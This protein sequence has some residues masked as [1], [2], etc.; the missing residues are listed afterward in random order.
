MHL[1][2]MWVHLENGAGEYLPRKHTVLVKPAPNAS[3]RHYRRCTR[4]LVFPLPPAL[5]HGS[6]HVPCRPGLRYDSGGAIMRTCIQAAGKI[7]LVIPLG[8]GM[9]VS[10]L[11]ASAQATS[12]SKALP[13]PDDSTAVQGKPN[14][15]KRAQLNLPPPK[16]W[17]NP[18]VHERPYAF[19]RSDV[20]EYRPTPKDSDFRLESRAG[21]AVNTPLLAQERRG[22]LNCF[23]GRL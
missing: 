13:M 22:T 10:T 1:H 11:D 2:G 3:R 15:Q 9:G 6:R 12:S 5:A 7:A 16:G 8:V 14:G 23:Q 18:L 20:L 4:I 17:P 21:M 19:L